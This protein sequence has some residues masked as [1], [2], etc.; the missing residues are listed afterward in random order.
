MALEG[1]PTA[2]L[3]SG[4]MMASAPPTMELAHL[5]HQLEEPG[6]QYTIATIWPAKLDLILGSTR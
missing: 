2:F 6:F 5:K 4:E 1:E 3:P